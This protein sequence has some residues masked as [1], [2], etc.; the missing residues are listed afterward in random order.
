MYARLLLSLTSLGLSRPGLAQEPPP[1][2]PPPDDAEEADDAG[3]VMV[4]TGTKT[5]HRLSDAT[6][7]TEVVTREEIEASGARDAGE[8][9]RMH[10][11]I[12]V[13]GSFRGA[14]AELRGL[15]PK[16]VLVI[17]DGVRV[18]GKSDG[19]VDLSRFSAEDIEQIEI[20]KGP[21]SALYGADALGGVIH[22][23]TR[24]PRS[25]VEMSLHTRA[26]TRA[27]SATPAVTEVPTDGLFP[28]NLPGVD[29]LDLEGR[30]G[31][32]GERLSTRAALGT[33][34]SAAYDLEPDDEDTSG[35]AWRE[36]SAAD[37]SELRLNDEARLALD[38]GYRR[39]ETRGVD[40]GAGGAV[41]DL[42]NL[43]EDAHAGL[44]PDLTLGASSRLQLGGKLSLYRDQFLQDQRLSDELD[45]YND[46]LERL[47]E[48]NAQLIRGWGDRHT[49][50]VG[51]DGLAERLASDRL[52]DDD[53]SRQRGAIFAQHEW[54]VLQDQGVSRLVLL[55][56]LRW[57]LDTQFGQALSPKLALRLDPVES[58]LLRASYGWGYRAPDFKELY[59]YFENPTAGYFVEGNPALR[60]ETSRSV[61]LGLTVEPSR[62]L[63]FGLTAFRNDVDDLIEP[64]LVAD[65]PDETDGVAPYRM[66]NI[67]RALTQ[68]VELTVASRVRDVYA[69]DAGYTFL[70]TLNRELDLPL[71]G[72]PAHRLTLAISSPELLW[73]VAATLRGAASSQQPYYADDDGDGEIELVWAPGTVDLGAR[74]SRPLG[75]VLSLTLGA[76][77]LLD[78]GD[79]TYNRLAPRLVYLGLDADWP[80]QREED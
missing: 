27:A 77:N 49:S 43:T 40:P 41:Y 33:R 61:D 50:T 73:G 7:A 63:R 29:A 60:P 46:A 52:S 44:A 51:L 8:V 26:G 10:A 56:G 5:P 13:A 53:V 48:L 25:P 20:I 6:V 69:L 28:A 34:G 23:R 75:Q 14:S 37:R 47:T 21:A 15:D 2:A 12:D 68:G 39:R 17:V 58:V 70:N 74:L 71:E 1:A 24:R 42:T 38:V 35:S 59:L 4:I 22:I 11:G 64:T 31:L 32:V 36:W 76:D 30:L 3:E 72:R 9:L 55:P 65:D 54:K 19:A 78:T 45:L 67:A 62:S 66:E 79:P 80:G 18:A 57:D 16:Y